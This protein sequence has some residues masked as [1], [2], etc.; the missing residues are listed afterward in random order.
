MGT[1]WDIGL[2]EKKRFDVCGLQGFAAVTSTLKSYVVACPSPLFLVLQVHIAVA[3]SVLL[4]SRD[5]DKVCGDRDVSRCLFCSPYRPTSLDCWRSHSRG[6]DCERG[7]ACLCVD[8]TEAPSG[9][10][11]HG[12]NPPKVMAPLIRIKL[13]MDP[14]NHHVAITGSFKGA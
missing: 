12:I 4:V 13:Q 5:L 7:C 14:G 8:G 10:A 3:F 2:F 11:R 9:L 6:D 1:P